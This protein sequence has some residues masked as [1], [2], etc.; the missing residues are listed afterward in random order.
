MPSVAVNVF[1]QLWYPVILPRL[2]RFAKLAIRIGVLMPEAPMYKNYLSAGPE[3][4]IR[5]TRQLS[6]MQTVT[7]AEPMEGR[8]HLHLGFSILALDAGHNPRSSGFRD[9]IH[10][11]QTKPIKGG[12]R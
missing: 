8:P 1:R 3:H 7:I 11:C 6:G 4:D 10:W 12:F 5:A 2:R 9:Y